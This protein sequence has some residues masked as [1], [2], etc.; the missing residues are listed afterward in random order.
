MK[1]NSVS[2]GRGR[3]AVAVLQRARKKYEST[4]V[5]QSGQQSSTDLRHRQLM[6][7]WPIWIQRCEDERGFQVNRCRFLWQKVGVLQEQ[8]VIGIS[9]AE[10][11]TVVSLIRLGQKMGDGSEVSHVRFGDK[12]RVHLESPKSSNQGRLVWYGVRISKV[13]RWTERLPLLFY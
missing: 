13:S 8:L 12:A 10:A 2:N 9:F 6:V 3:L 5:D 7:V 1:S 11:V 4:G